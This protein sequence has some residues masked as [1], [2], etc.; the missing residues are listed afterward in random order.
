MKLRSLYK[1]RTE[2]LGISM[3]PLELK[4]VLNGDPERFYFQWLTDSSLIISLNLSFGSNFIW[5]INRPNTRSEIIFYGKLTEIENSQT[6]IELKTR[7]KTFLAILFLVLPLL[8]LFLQIMIKFEWPI[9]LIQFAFFPLAIIGLLN[10]IRSEE[11]R[12]LAL[13]KEHLNNEIM[14][15]ENLVAGNL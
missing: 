14:K 4:K 3:K 12:L 15:H 7:S 5:D 10:F 8:V 9:F 13:F 6:K 2:N 11:R 1:P